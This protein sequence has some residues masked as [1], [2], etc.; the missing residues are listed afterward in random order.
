[1]ADRIGDFEISDQ[2]GFTKQY[3]GSVGTTAVQVP[4]VALTTKIEGVLIRSPNQTPNNRE[5]QYSFDNVTYHVL[6]PGE[7]VAWE[8]RD[9]D[10]IGPI[11]QLWFKSNTGT[12]NY[13]VTIDRALN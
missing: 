12:V 4:A 11:F 7:F 10:G 8:I 6:L 13:E 5:L 9:I 1:M 3:A 2:G